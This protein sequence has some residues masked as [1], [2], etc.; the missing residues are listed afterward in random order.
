MLPARMNGN[1]YDIFTRGV[2]SFVGGHFT[3]FTSRCVNTAWRSS[4]TLPQRSKEFSKYMYHQRFMATAVVRS[5]PRDLYARANVKA[6][7]YATE[8]DSAEVLW[9]R[10]WKACQQVRNTPGIYERVVSQWYV[11]KMHV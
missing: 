2:T 4:T 1:Q 8:Q 3:S 10:V 5:Q 7:V 11:E 6:V 9:Q